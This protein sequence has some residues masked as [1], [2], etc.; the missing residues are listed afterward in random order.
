MDLAFGLPSIFILIGVVIIV[1]GFIL[2][3]DTLFAAFGLRLG[4]HVQFIRP[5]ILPMAANFNIVPTSI[6][7]IKDLKWGIIKYQAPVA[8]V[9]LSLHIVL[10]YVLAF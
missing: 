5:L 10:M 8:I 9:M 3:L 7:E 6:L 4:G 1:V 2:K